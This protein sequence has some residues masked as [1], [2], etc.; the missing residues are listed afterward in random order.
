M[1]TMWHWRHVSRSTYF[2]VARCDL[3]LRE[4]VLDVG[5]NLLRFVEGDRPVC[6][7]SDKVTRSLDDFRGFGAPTFPSNQKSEARS[8]NE[9]S[10]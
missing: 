1:P 8:K 9:D 2:R 10:N 6:E 7:A 5:R 4:D 3:G